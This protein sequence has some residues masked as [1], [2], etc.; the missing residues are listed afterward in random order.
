MVYSILDLSLAPRTQLQTYYPFLNFFHPRAY[1]T[2]FLL[3]ALFVLVSFL[4]ARVTFFRT[5]LSLVL[6]VL[7]AVFL[8]HVDAD[9]FAALLITAEVPIILIAL[10]F[11]FSKFSLQVDTTYSFSVPPLKKQLFVFF[12]ILL[13]FFLCIVVHTHTFAISW[14][15]LASRVISSCMVFKSYMCDRVVPVGVY[16]FFNLDFF[17]DCT[18][19]ELIYSASRND[20]YL[21]FA[22][23]YDINC[24]FIFI[25]GFLLFLVSCLCIFVYFSIKKLNKVKD[26]TI[27]NIMFAR[28]QSMTRQATVDARLK[29]FKRKQI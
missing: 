28:K 12:S 22:I 24:F 5:L 9:Y 7:Y 20:F 13:G 27:K 3:V 1:F 15:L 4:S 6:T 10:L 18:L 16:S 11:Y 23:Y 2:L 26:Y 8:C 19:P 29:F 25:F 21:L 14:H 17:F